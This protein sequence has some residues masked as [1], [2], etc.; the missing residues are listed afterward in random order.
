MYQNLFLALF[1]TIIFWMFNL[2]KGNGMGGVWLRPNDKGKIIFA[3]RSL[4][5][6]LIEPLY[7]CFYWYPINWDINFY[8]IFIVTYLFV[9]LLTNLEP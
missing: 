2:E 5:K 8:A 6:L 4:I 1:I 9:S 3:Y 7:N